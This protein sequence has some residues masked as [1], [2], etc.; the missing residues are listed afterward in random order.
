MPNWV[1]EGYQEYAKRLPPRISI[2]L[3]EVALARRTNQTNADKLK[4][5]E[6]EAIL[7]GIKNT[8]HVVALDV[9]G[10]SFATEQLAAKL[11]NWEMEGVG[12]VVI[13]IGGPDGLSSDC[14]NRA[15]ETWSL[16]K[17]TLPH[18]LVRV[19]FIEQIYRAC[20]INAG[21]PYHRE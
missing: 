16:S 18:P 19:V 9:K 17:L 10:K 11:S 5:A 14:L 1:S 6:G 12:Q 15:N 20:M 3:K 2:Q 21:H 8:D 7:D 4:Q 13:L